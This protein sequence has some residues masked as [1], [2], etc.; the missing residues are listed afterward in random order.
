MLSDESNSLETCTYVSTKSINKFKKMQISSWT[1]LYIYIYIYI[2][3]LQASNLSCH[4]KELWYNETIC[5][6]ISLSL[7]IYIYTYVSCMSYLEVFMIFPDIRGVSSWCNVRDGLRNRSK[8]VRTPV[9][10]LRSL[11]SK[12]PWE[13]YKPLYPPSYG[14]NSTTTVLPGE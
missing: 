7:Y 12:H 2:S 13:R 11:S 10:L 8:G 3:Q 6:W 9:A 1:C 5:L 4:T 14:L